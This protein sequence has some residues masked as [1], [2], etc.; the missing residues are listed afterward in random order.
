VRYVP[1]NLSSS[2][3]FTIS[4]A[5]R[6]SHPYY[7]NLYR[8]STHDTPTVLYINSLT[9]KFLYFLY[10]YLQLY[11]THF[12]LGFFSNNAYLKVHLLRRLDK[13]F[14]LVQV[15]IVCT[16]TTEGTSYLKIVGTPATS[17]PCTTAAL[18]SFRTTPSSF[19]LYSN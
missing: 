18:R 12:V 10:F 5:N 11:C 1:R 14:Q 17:L 7:I 6:T 3:N 4:S 2:V 8:T 19:W 13:A 16:T 15:T 9:K